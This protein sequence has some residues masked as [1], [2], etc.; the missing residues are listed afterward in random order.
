MAGPGRTPKHPSERHGHRS[1]TE[2]KLTVLDAGA[3]TPPPPTPEFLRYATDET[4]EWWRTWQASPQAQQFV[5][6]DWQRL[7]MLAP[8]VDRY[9]LDPT[10]SLL[11]EIRLSESLLGATVAD[12][13]RLRQEV[14]PAAPESRLDAI[15]A[16]RIRVID[17][18]PTNGS[19][20]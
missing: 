2:K 18:G 3:T 7:A 6:T 12:R 9:F 19:A 14:K 20:S 1:R 13:L 10:T 17:P 4:V 8:L 15:K 16:R 5:G 11:A